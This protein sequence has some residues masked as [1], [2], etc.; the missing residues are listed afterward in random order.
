MQRHLPGSCTID[1]GQGNA[2][3]DLAVVLPIGIDALLMQADFLVEEELITR[4]ASQGE[5]AHP[6]EPFRCPAWRPYFLL[7]SE[8]QLG[9]CIVRQIAPA[10][11]DELMA[12]AR[13][14]H[15]GGPAAHADGKLIDLP[16]PLE[17]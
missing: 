9:Q 14:G 4:R 10:G 16:N 3:A 2:P 17:V 8:Q 1:A 7:R 6:V 5:L 12:K 13:S 15:L 11:G